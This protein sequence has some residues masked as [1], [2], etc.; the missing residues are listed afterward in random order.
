MLLLAPRH[1]LSLSISNRTSFL[2]LGLFPPL[3]LLQMPMHVTKIYNLSHLRNLALR[4]EPDH[5]HP[6]APK[7]FVC[8]SQ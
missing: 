6:R 3:M 5:I 2:V 1:H 4:I 7:G 8:Q